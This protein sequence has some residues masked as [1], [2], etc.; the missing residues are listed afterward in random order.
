M[1]GPLR[2]ALRQSWTAPGGRTGLVVLLSMA[3]IVLL[4]PPWLADPAAIPDAAAGALA[5]GTGHLFGTDQLNRDVLARLVTGGRVSLMIAGLAV[6]LAMTLVAGVGLVAGYA[7]GLI[8]TILTRLVDGALAIP[9]IFLLLLLVL[10]WERVPVVALIVALGITGWLETARLVRGE[11]LRLRGEPYVLAAR[12]LGASPARIILHHLL[13]NAMGPLL[14]AATLGDV[15]LLEAGLSF[16]GLGIQPPTPSW[17]VMILEARPILLSAPWAGLFPGAA[18]V[19]TV[20]AANLVGDA[21]QS[22]LDP[23]TA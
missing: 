12:A 10:V 8:D 1:I 13:P 9:R 4:A 23:R 6:A 15:I 17:G 22:A 5:P 21:L 18:I 19:I 3:V 16:L 7:G 2:Q 20:L 11:V 14:V